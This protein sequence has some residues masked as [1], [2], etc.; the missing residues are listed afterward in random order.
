MAHPR[1]VSPL[2]VGGAHDKGLTEM[3][4]SFP[5]Q[6]ALF[7]YF[8]LCLKINKIF[9]AKGKGEL[10]ADWVKKRRKIKTRRKEQ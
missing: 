3:P 7:E 10:E 1:T 4:A 8:R 6:V 2:R 5:S 9:W